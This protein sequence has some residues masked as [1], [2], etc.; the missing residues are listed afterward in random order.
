MTTYRVWARP[1]PITHQPRWMLQGG[2]PEGWEL[3]DAAAQAIRWQNL[4]PDHEVAV[5]PLMGT[6]PC[7]TAELSRLAGLSQ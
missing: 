1:R 7:T 4:Y 3:R 6:S 2:P 5:L